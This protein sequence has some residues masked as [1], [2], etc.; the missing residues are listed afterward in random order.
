MVLVVDDEEPD[1]HA[2]SYILRKDSYAV[3]EAVSY[4]DA[5]ALFDLNQDAVKLL[6]ADVSPPDGNGCALATP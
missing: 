6:V 1:R 4:S 2:M 3:L 5:M